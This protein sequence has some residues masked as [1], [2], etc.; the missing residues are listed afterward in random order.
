MCAVVET[1]FGRGAGGGRV[2]ELGGGAG[3]GR[4]YSHSIWQYDDEMKSVGAP[5]SAHPLQR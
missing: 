3:G 4:P 5:E 1:T 2:A